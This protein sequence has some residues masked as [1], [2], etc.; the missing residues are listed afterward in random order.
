M[1]LAA[2]IETHGYWVLAVGCFLEGETILVLAGYAAYR[3]Y[4]NP[5]A[6]IAIASTAG[7][8]GD[9]FFFW[10]GRRHGAALLSRWPALAKQAERVQRMLA[11]YHEAV[12][13]GMRFAY[14]LRIAG[15]VLMGTTSVPA[16]RF[17]VLN[18]LG[19][20]LWACVVGGLGWVF[21]DVAETVF[22][23]IRRFEGWLLLGL[24]LAGAVAWW[25]GRRRRR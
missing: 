22:S 5:V 1:T 8:A 6:V 25:L 24:V 7:F 11:R 13:I 3:G 21:G 23:E 12:I 4:L 9:Q 14:G 19:A 15:P 20:L 18:A 16:L 10:L 17:G 2:L